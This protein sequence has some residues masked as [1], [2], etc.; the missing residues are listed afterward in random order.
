MLSK[1]DDQSIDELLKDRI[2][3]R[4]KT[5]DNLQYILWPINFST[6]AVINRKPEADQFSSPVLDIQMD[7]DVF[8]VRMT[9]MQFE[10]LLLLL[11]AIDRMNLGKPY[12]KWRPSVPIKGH[13][14]K[15][16]NF[17]FTAIMETDI[18]RRSTNWSWIMI[19]E[20]RIKMNRYQELYKHKLLSKN[21]DSIKTEIERL[22]K[23]LNLFSIVLA[24]N[25]AEVET[26]QILKNK[27]EE[28]KKGWFSGWFSKEETKAEGKLESRISV[29][30]TIIF[31]ENIVNEFKKE[32]N[33]KEKQKLYEA[34][35][36][37]EG[38]PEELPSS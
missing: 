18:K 22:E 34:I 32:M 1:L 3:N 28:P 6:N 13:S 23:D 20:H 4:H 15:W 14:K 26:Q 8:E 36:Y 33:T 27:K 25:Q 2:A 12:R 19:R 5:P 37:E 38:I 17:A 30:N 9:R 16:W 21:I 29:N 11:D 35:G 7:L 24:R 31:V 10:S